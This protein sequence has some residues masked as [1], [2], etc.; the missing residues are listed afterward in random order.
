MDGAYDAI[1]KLEI[2]TSPNNM[3]V[4]IHINYI[5]KTDKLNKDKTISNH[6]VKKIT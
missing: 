6:T 5:P 4:H 1:R 3:E 2:L